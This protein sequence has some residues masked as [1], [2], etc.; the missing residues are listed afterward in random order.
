[1]SIT[2][3]LLDLSHDGI[4]WNLNI[5]IMDGGDAIVIPISDEKKQ[6]LENAG[7]EIFIY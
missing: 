6:E 1:M 3:A 7:V 4:T 2:K 5:D